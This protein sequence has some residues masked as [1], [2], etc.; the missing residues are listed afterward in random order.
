MYSIVLFPRRELSLSLEMVSTSL[1]L[2][3]SVGAVVALG[4]LGRSFSLMAETRQLVTSGPF[5]FVRHP[6]YLAEEIAIVG[7]FIQFVSLWIAI[8]LAA[9]YRCPIATDAQRGFGSGHE[10]P[11]IR[12]LPTK[13]R[14]SDPR[15]LLSS[16]KNLS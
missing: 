10:L 14:A 13:H 9:A 6:L 1:P 7:L 3:G 15:H 12:R 8:L 2:I 4:Q 11:R 5:H 16:A